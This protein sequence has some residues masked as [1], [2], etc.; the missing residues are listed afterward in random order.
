MRQVGVTPRTWL[1]A[2]RARA[3]RDTFQRIGLVRLSFVTGRAFQFRLSATTRFLR[4]RTHPARGDLAHCGQRQA[5]RKEPDFRDGKSSSHSHIRKAA[6][7]SWA[8]PRRPKTA[9]HAVA[10]EIRPYP[11]IA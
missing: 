5:I 1:S 3:M 6:A 11:R 9:A 4:R 8:Q 10:G 2:G 7:E